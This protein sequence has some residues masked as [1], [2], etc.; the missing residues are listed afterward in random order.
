M[1]W[2]QTYTGKRMYFDRPKLCDID[3]RDIAHGLSNMCRFNGQ[4]REF[5]SVAQHCVLVSHI[6]PRGA[7]LWGLLHD[8]SEAYLP[9]V[10]TPLK[11]LMPQFKVFEEHIQEAIGDRF[12]LAWP[13][14][15]SVKAADRVALATEARDLMRDGE[16]LN[17]LTAPPLRT[18]VEPL[19]PKVA[20]VLFLECFDQYHD[21]V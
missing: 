16:A 8:A 1:H 20:E 2:V 4:T 9:D 10:T 15:P 6:V 11:A 17:G 14:P 13:M 7:E 12:G 18:R 5:Y 21:A 19:P 3:I